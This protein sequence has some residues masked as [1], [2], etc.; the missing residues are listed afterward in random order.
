[1]PPRFLFP[2]FDDLPITLRHMLVAVLLSWLLTDRTLRFNGLNMLP[3]FLP[4]FDLPIKLLMVRSTLRL[5]D[6]YVF[7]TRRLK[8]VNIYIERRQ[9]N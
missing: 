3:F 7:L 8:G 1:V 6:L 5:M 2:R 9:K 4:F